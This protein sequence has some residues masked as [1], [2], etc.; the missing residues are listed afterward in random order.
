[1]IKY[2]C[3]RLQILSFYGEFEVHASEYIHL[4]QAAASARVCYL[5]KARH[6]IP[7]YQRCIY[8]YRSRSNVALCCIYVRATNAKQRLT[9]RSLSLSL[10]FFLLL[11]LQRRNSTGPCLSRPRIILRRANHYY[12]SPAASTFLLICLVIKRVIKSRSRLWSVGVAVRQ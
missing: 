3:Q 4:M 11:L 1:M 8:L 12:H 6:V 10:G 9:A 7:P 5:C 2:S